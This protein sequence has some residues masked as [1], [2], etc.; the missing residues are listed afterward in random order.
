MEEKNVTRAAARLFISQPA[1][2]KSLKRMRQLFNDPLFTR[3]AHGLIATPR[4]ETLQKEIPSLL[5]KMEH[6]ISNQGFQA[7]TYSGSFKIACSDTFGYLLPAL[8]KNL[9]VAAPQMK[10]EHLPLDSDYEE[11]L[12]RGKIDFVI[13]KALIPRADIIVDTLNMASMRCLMRAQHPLNKKQQLSLDDYLAYS[14][15]RHVISNI[16]ISGLGL[17][18]ELL[19][20]QQL[21]RKITFATPYMELAL[22]VVEQ[23]DYL[24]LVSTPFD[25]QALNQDRFHLAKMPALLAVPSKPFKLL[26][27]ARSSQNPAHKW[28]RQQIIKAA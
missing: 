10:I 3:T 11:S 19:A 22:R 14:H 12:R 7:E 23:T 9:A 8:L 2:S 27:H 1:M 25:V 24:V 20:K 26:H 4:A 5:A 28:L 17:I 21:Q 18:D 13:H 6:L 16:T 15:V